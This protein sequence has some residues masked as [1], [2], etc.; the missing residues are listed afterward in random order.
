MKLSIL[1]VCLSL[2]HSSLCAPEPIRRTLRVRGL[3]PHALTGRRQG[4]GE[5]DALSDASMPFLRQ[6]QGSNANSSELYE[7]WVTNT[8]WMPPPKTGISMPY[9]RALIPPKARRRS[10]LKNRSKLGLH[11]KAKARVTVSVGSHASRGTGRDLTRGPNASPSRSSFGSVSSQD[12]FERAPNL[13]RSPTTYKPTRVK[14][15]RKSTRL[16]S[17]HSGES[18]MPSSA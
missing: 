1:L 5:R 7:Y 11:A 2:A 17:S 14:E 16:N 18:R 8:T 3:P 9:R 12:S 10:L 4:L 6:L 15:D 13:R